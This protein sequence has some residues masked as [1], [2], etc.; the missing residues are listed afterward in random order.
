MPQL[1]STGILAQP[2][3]EDTPTPDAH[4]GAVAHTQS[5]IPVMRHVNEGSN[6]PRGRRT[7]TTN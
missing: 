4:K 5:G 2:A 1:A 3:R 7:L 6:I